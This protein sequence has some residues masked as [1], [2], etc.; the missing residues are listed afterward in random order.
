MP[1]LDLAT[2][3]SDYNPDNMADI[4]PAD[5]NYCMRKIFE[6]QVCKIAANTVSGGQKTL[7]QIVNEMCLLLLT[8]YY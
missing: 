3:P 1:S 5:C 6:T 2:L 4:I 7:T 8:P